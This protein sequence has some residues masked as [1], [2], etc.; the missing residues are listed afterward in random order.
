MHTS[1]HIHYKP[2]HAF[3][4]MQPP[5]HNTRHNNRSALCGEPSEPHNNG[6]TAVYVC[7][8]WTMKTVIL[9]LLFENCLTINICA[10]FAWREFRLNVISY[11]SISTRQYRAAHYNKALPCTTPSQIKIVYHII[12][13]QYRIQYS[14]KQYRIPHLCNFLKSYIILFNVI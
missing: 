1:M 3:Y 14:T 6:G 5:S 2:E 13:K 11:I 4:T 7:S 9:Q 10:A 8:L 12:V